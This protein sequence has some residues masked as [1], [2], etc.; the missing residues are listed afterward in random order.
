MSRISED[1]MS[2][3]KI[4]DNC[5]CRACG[6]ADPDNLHVDH[7]IPR[8]LG[9]DD[10]LNNLQTLCGVCNNIKGNVNVG[11]L[12]ILPKISGFGDFREVMTR[13]AEFRTMVKECRKKMIENAVNTVKEWRVNGVSGL[14]IRK[15]LGKM[16]P[17]RH[18]E[19]ILVA[20]R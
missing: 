20:T 16:V 6:M 8:S 7:I 5:R 9:G 13:R 19:N 10:R 17:S 2:M 3:V 4:R 12:D 1:I 14:T 11:E 15:R 18:I